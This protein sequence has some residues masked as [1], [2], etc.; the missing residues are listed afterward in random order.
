MALRWY[1]ICFLF[2]MRNILPNLILLG[3][4]LPTSTF[5]Q[6]GVGFRLGDPSGISVKKYWSGHAFEASLGRTHLFR[7]GGYYRDRYDTWYADQRFNYTAHE[8]QGYRATPALGL[9]LHY[10]IQ[11][12][13]RNAGDL[14]WYYGFGGQVRSQQYFY[15]YRYKP[16]PGNDWV[17]VRDER[18]TNIDLGVDGVVGLEY[19]FNNA[20]VSIF[21]D[22]TLFMEL[23]DDPF[24][25]RPQLGLGARFRF[26]GA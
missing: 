17:V 26:G 9:Q 14:D 16:G 11:K 3:A 18:V 23:L 6:W 10:L 22:L 25:F 5:A 20:P 12:D 19:N 1:L 13:L 21:T 15:D 4:L 24:V 8:F 2:A 7:N